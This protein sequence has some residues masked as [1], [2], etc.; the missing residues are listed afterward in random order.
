[1]QRKRNHKQS[2]KQNQTD[3]DPT[4]YWDIE[5]VKDINENNKEVLDFEDNIYNL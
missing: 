2:I 1:M 3:E 5:D 4:I